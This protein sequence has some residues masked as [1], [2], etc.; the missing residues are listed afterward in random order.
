MRDGV[1]A[2]L[3]RHAV[4]LSESASEFLFGIA[5]EVKIPVGRAKQFVVG[6]EVYGAS[7]F[8]SIMQPAET[9]EEW[10][11]STRFEGTGNSGRHARVKFGVGRGINPQ[12]GA[13]TWR[14]VL[15]IELFGWTK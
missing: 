3:S 10:L 7:A 2:L 9:D 14:V 1:D 13:P 11:I 12:F 4:R 8:R 6:S 5:G 15:A